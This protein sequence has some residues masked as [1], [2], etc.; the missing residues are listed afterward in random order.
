MRQELGVQRGAQRRYFPE[1]A[2]PMRETKNLVQEKL[3]GVIGE[4][5]A[6]DQ[7]FLNSPMQDINSPPAIL[8]SALR[9]TGN[10]PHLNESWEMLSGELQSGSAQNWPRLARAYTIAG[11]LLYQ[12]SLPTEKRM[13]STPLITAMGMSQKEASEWL[14]G[15]WI[16]DETPK[17]S[18][19]RAQLEQTMEEFEAYLKGIIYAEEPDEQT[20]RKNFEIACAFG[21]LR[22]KSNSFQGRLNDQ[23]VKLINYASLG[24]NA[25]GTE[26]AEELMIRR[27]IKD[28]PVPLRRPIFIEACERSFDNGRPIR[29]ELVDYFLNDEELQE[30]FN[31]LIVHKSS[32][33]TNIHIDTAMLGLL[34]QNQATVLKFLSTL[35]MPDERG[36][37]ASFTKRLILLTGLTK[38]GVDERYPKNANHQLL[39]DRLDQLLQPVSDRDR[40]AKYLAVLDDQMPGILYLSST[41]EVVAAT[42]AP[43]QTREEFLRQYEKVYDN[44]IYESQAGW[45]QP[46]PKVEAVSSLLPEVSVSDVQ[47]FPLWG[48]VGLIAGAA[49]TDFLTLVGNRLNGHGRSADQLFDLVVSLRQQGSLSTDQ[50][51]FVVMVDLLSENHP[52]AALKNSGVIAV[53]R[54]GDEISVILD[55]KRAKVASEADKLVLSGHID[56]AG[57][58]QLTGAPG[59]FNYSILHLLLNAAGLLGRSIVN[60]EQLSK[61]ELS[62]VRGLMK[63]FNKK[64]KEDRLPQLVFHEG[65]TPD[66]A[67]LVPYLTGKKGVFLAVVG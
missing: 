35:K 3:P 10:S 2:L 14:R 17:V 51:P 46:A 13:M 33:R 26:L 32:Q 61:E 8:L 37:Q 34:L 6:S 28:I 15:E 5:L 36:A 40:F 9:L 30:G 48:E 43:G 67:T 54:E 45:P 23:Q 22:M 65:R 52:L 56:S 58:L 59:E 24:I 41:L 60:E 47:V 66:N 57:E 62:E 19:P 12:T 50:R 4:M 1:L 11:L 29:D 7:G 39:R 63:S 38:R 20:I 55:T 53:G 16:D 44:L 21:D 31:A 18:L 64:A 25:V 27:A 49:I 42:P